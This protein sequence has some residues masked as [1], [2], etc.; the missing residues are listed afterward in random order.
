MLIVHLVKKTD[1]HKLTSKMERKKHRN[2]ELS[3]ERKQQ[4]N[5]QLKGAITILHE[6]RSHEI[7]YVTSDLFHR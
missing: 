1:S 3:N 6:T 7:Q 2:K 5:P 4:A